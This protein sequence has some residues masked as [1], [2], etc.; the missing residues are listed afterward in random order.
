[1]RHRYKRHISKYEEEAIIAEGRISKIDYQN[2][3][4]GEKYKTVFYV[5]SQLCPEGRMCV[6]WGHTNINVG[7]YVEMKGRFNDGIFLCWSMKI[8]QRRSK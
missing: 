1:M 4:I 5:P 8:M 6:K 2:Q 3:F 7:D